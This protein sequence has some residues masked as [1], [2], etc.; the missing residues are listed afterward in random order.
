MS[1]AR[2][3]GGA[4]MSRT[5]LVVAEGLSLMRDGLAMLLAG[6]PHGPVR[7]AGTLDE[8]VGLLSADQAAVLLLDEELPGGGTEA[9]QA[10]RRRFPGL[11]I[12]ALAAQES[13]DGVLRCLAAGAHGYVAKTA[14][15]TE[16]ARAIEAV[17]AGGVHVPAALA[18]PPGT[19]PAA[20]ARPGSGR[21]G[22]LTGRQRDVLL[23]LAEGRSTKDIARTLDL[24]VSTI[25][26][27]LAALYRV[28]G[29]RN[30]V[31]ALCRAGCLP[32][33]ERTAVE[34][35]SGNV[36]MR[37]EGFR[38]LDPWPAPAFIDAEQARRGA[39]R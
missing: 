33:P 27:H 6:W 16:L 17:R 11:R 7:M 14:S 9:T 31:E 19:R 23:L 2:P 32:G 21:I 34:A 13:R 36:M 39:F 26:V 25:K 37:Q 38:T 1:N 24:A 20:V 28:F 22:T 5:G 10:L 12:V 3:A 29:A 30:R 8:A 4:A 15:F 35:A 18:G